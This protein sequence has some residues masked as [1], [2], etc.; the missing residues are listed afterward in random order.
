[1]PGLH[2]L[3]RYSALILKEGPFDACMMDSAHQMLQ[4]CS[5]IGLPRKVLMCPMEEVYLSSTP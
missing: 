5:G 1:M 4:L 2:W 3:A